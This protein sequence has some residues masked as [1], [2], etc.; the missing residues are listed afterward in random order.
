MHSQHLSAVYG[1]GQLYCTS[2][3]SSRNTSITTDGQY[4]YLYIGH[5]QRG[6]MYKIGTGEAGTIA[7]KVHLHVSTDRE[8]DVTWVHCQGKLYSR[9]KD[10][11]FGNLA[12]YDPSNFKKLG[13]ARLVCGDLF[14]GNKTLRAQNAPYPMLSDGEHVYIITFQVER[15]ERK[16]KESLAAEARAL[17]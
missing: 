17:A 1:V 10:D 4:L 7:G 5:S 2:R 3:L 9:R 12:V 15:R 8:G 16:P 6:A 14:G 13:E 11:E